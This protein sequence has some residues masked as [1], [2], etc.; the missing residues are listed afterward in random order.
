MKSIER[1]QRPLK[2]R[3]KNAGLF[4]QLSGSAVLSMQDALIRSCHVPAF[5]CSASSADALLFIAVLVQTGYRHASPSVVATELPGVGKKQDANLS[6][7]EID[8]RDSASRTAAI[9]TQPRNLGLP[10]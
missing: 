9:K 2:V 6:P 8:L 7:L 10:H 4:G 1:R 5:P 3:R